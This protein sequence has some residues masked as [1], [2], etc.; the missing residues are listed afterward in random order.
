MCYIRDT[1][2]CKFTLVTA[3]GEDVVSSVYLVFYYYYLALLLCFIF[4]YF[5]LM[6]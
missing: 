4:I 3:F 5:L 6:L 2:T 1:L